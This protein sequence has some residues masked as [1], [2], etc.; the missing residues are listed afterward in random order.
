MNRNNKL[1]IINIGGKL[2][3]ADQ[4]VFIIA[5]AGVN[6][7]GRLDLALKLIDAAAEA[8]ADAVKFQTFR[9][10]QVVTVSGKMA[11]Y[12]KRN[13]GKSESQLEMLR[14][15]ELDEKY[16]PRLIKYARK[17]KIIFL[18][19]PHGGFESV[20]FLNKIGIPAFK[21]GS[22]DLTNLPFLEYT[23]KFKKPMIISAGMATF[24]EIKEAVGTI[25]KAGNNKIIVLH[26]TTD[27]PCPSKEVN[28]SAMP[29]IAGKIGVLAGYSDHT[30]G[31]QV[32]VMASVL[33]ACMIEKHLT[34][35]KKMPGPDHKASADP[36][37]FKA[38]ADQIRKG[39]LIL[40]SPVKKPSKNEL[41][42]IPLMR[43]SVVCAADI[44]KGEYF[45]GKNL[46]IK[47]PGTG[48]PPKYFLKIIGK[49]A[50]KSIRVG[51]LIGKSDI[52]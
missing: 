41:A 1:N 22:G 48:L 43:K 36:G 51:Q 10:E 12:Q 19:T 9:A 5:E 35:D 13:L 15:L 14:K 27:Y 23:A 28:L 40:G 47:R 11:D 6:H 24:D 18:S 42:Y 37:E 45:T 44:K 50:Q 52:K 7:K 4:P 30:L 34:L 46:A 39:N 26:C 49:T 38:M 2:I 17:K 20:D 3:G 33:G 32:A 29:V 25:R 16:Y 21:F 31:S 8:G